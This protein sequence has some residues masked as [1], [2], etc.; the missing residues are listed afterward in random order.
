TEA[1][2]QAQRAD[3]SFF[4]LKIRPVLAGTCLPCHGGKKL[5][6]GL[7]V[8]SRAALLKGGDSGPALVPGDPEKSLLI[9]A[10]R[11]THAGIKMP[12]NKRLA[13]AVVADFVTWGKQGAPWPRQTTGTPFQGKGRWAFQP[14]KPVEPPADPQGWAELPIDCFIAAKLRQQG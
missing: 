12:P 3:E 5:S 1:R 2:G 9:Q 11:Q 6:H 4:E 14:V 13:V 8:D 10:I 7:R